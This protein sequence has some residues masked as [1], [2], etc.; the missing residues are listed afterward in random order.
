MAQHAILRFT[1]AQGPPTELLEAH[2]E[3]KR[4]STPATRTLTPAGAEYNSISFKPDGRYYHFIQSRIKQARC[5]TGDSTWFR[6]AGLPLSA[7]SFSRAGPQGDSAYFQRAADSSL[8]GWVGRTSFRLWYT[9]MKTPH[10]HSLV[11]FV[12]CWTSDNRLCAKEIIGNRQSDEVAG[13]FFTPV[14]VEQYLPTWSVGK[15]QQD[16]PEALIP[17][18][19]VQTGGQP[20]QTG[21]GL[22]RFSLALLPLNA[23]KKKEGSPLHA[24]KW[25]PQMENFSG[26][27]KI[28]G[29]NQ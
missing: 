5:R 14:A 22:K 15:R 26:N 6:H 20:L 21:E 24:E 19:A 28:Q 11:F 2:H 10:L 13:R 8:T 4:S 23:G 29:H 16:G 27:R 7:R 12:R 3:R 1:E 18:P 9:W 25:F 17:H